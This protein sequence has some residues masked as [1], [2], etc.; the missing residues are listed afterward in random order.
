MVW[1]ACVCPCAAR[2]VGRLYAG[3]LGAVRDRWQFRA[4]W[5]SGSRGY[6]TAVLQKRPRC[7]LQKFWHWCPPFLAVSSLAMEGKGLKVSVCTWRRVL[8]ASREHQLCFH[9]GG[10]QGDLHHVTLTATLDSEWVSWMSPGPRISWVRWPTL[11]KR[12][13]EG[14]S[15]RQTYHRLARAAEREPCHSA[16]QWGLEESSA[17]GA[18]RRGMLLPVTRERRAVGV[19]RADTP[20]CLSC[21]AL[22]R[23]VV[24][25]CS[26]DRKAGQLTI[27]AVRSVLRFG[28][29]P[30]DPCAPSSRHCIGVR[31]LSHS[32]C[33]FGGLGIYWAFSC[34]RKIAIGWKGKQLQTEK[35][36]VR[37]SRGTSLRRCQ[38]RGG[39]A[40]PA[41]S[42]ALVRNDL[43][44]CTL[45]KGCS[46]SAPCLLFHVWSKLV[47]LH[48]HT[49]FSWDRWGG[50]LFPPL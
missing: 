22:C 30:L 39:C 18:F 8:R 1:G 2:L 27:S 11:C 15:C 49:D 9:P 6:C 12:V 25:S 31:G 29:D 17:P 38:P 41:T 19:G 43:E 34:Y 10:P 48:L 20:G 32:L 45:R 23:S 5:F 37:K 47:L 40:G 7:L 26:A 50:L 24:V 16:S 4:C 44:R 42:T 46:K 3:T 28:R 21:A 14:L 35:Y 13:R 36:R 33:P